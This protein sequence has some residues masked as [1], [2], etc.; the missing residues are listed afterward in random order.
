MK[1]A[2]IARDP[3]VDLYRED[4]LYGIEV[5]EAN[6]DREAISVSYFMTLCGLM[7]HAV[8]CADD[9]ELGDCDKKDIRFYDK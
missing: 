5:V 1:Y 8:R 7:I 2:V 6:S 3:T 4:D 9:M